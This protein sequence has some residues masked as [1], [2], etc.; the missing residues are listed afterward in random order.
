MFSLIHVQLIHVHVKKD[1]SV[2]EVSRTSLGVDRQR[3][4][5]VPF[6]AKG[7]DFGMLGLGWR[8]TCEKQCL[9]HPARAAQKRAA[10]VSK[11]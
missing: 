11:A 5:T 8:R 1:L 3:K 7:S 9:R 4:V 10:D 2:L 6:A